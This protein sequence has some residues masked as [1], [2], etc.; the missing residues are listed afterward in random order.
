MEKVEK[1][2]DVVIHKTKYG[3]MNWS[4]EK[5]IFNS[6]TERK[7]CAKIDNETSIS[8]TLNYN[9]NSLAKTTCFTLNNKQFHSGYKVFSSEKT[10]ILAKEIFPKFQHLFY[11]DSNTL[12]DI[13]T[14]IS[15]VSL[16]RDNKI[17]SVLAKV[18][19]E[20]ENK[21]E[22]FLDKLKFW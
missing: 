15:D 9:N 22:K 18:N 21:S 6:E 4:E 13:L 3:S 2:L 16:V 1:I 19:S 17:N 7:V 5:S 12:D 14:K 10:N 20:P 8:L 11:N